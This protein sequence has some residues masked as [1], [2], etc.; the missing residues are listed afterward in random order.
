MRTCLLLARCLALRKLLISSGPVAV[1]HLQQA[2]QWQ[3]EL[4]RSSSSVKS[5]TDE[6]LKEDLPKCE[7]VKKDSHLLTTPPSTAVCGLMS[8]EGKPASLSS[9]DSGFEGAGS[10]PVEAC[11]GREAVEGL[12]G[13]SETRESMRIVLNQP[14][15]HS[16]GSVFDP[17]DHREGLD[18]GSVGNSSRA[19]IQLAPREPVESLNFE[20]KVKRSAA[21]P[22]N[23]WLSLPV[24]D[25]ENLYTVTVTPNPT[26]PKRDLHFPDPLEPCP[27]SIQPGQCRDQP[28]QTEVM[29]RTQFGGT[30]NADWILHSRS[31][32]FE[33]SELSPMGGILSSTIDVGDKSMCTTEGVPTLLWDSYDLH[34][35]KQDSV[36]G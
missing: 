18:F 23:P 36:D 17:E 21:L 8:A 16:V 1:D 12:S 29:S 7:S 15:V 10:C 2:L 14:Q 4:L 3:Y 6:E 33:D 35:Q 32:C 13:S 31:S 25:L 24:D 27:R 34:E 19:S 22:S 5:N 11:G 26:P 30:R 28:T 20:I 9:F